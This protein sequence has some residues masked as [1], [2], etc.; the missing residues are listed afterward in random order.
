MTPSE[1]EV[2]PKGRGLI[3][4]WLQAQ[5]ELAQ[6]NR[7]VNSAECTVKNSHDALAKWLAPDDIEIEEKISVWMGDSLFQVEKM[8]GLNG[9]LNVTVRTR[10]RK[11]H[12][13]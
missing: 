13:L 6:A 1:E 9:A 4:K 8:A 7:A 2:V 12:E 5:E 10:G 3:E 11:F